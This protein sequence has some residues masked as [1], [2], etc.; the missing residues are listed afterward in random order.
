MKNIYEI[1]FSG[2]KKD[3]QRY[4]P[5]DDQRDTSRLPNRHYRVNEFNQYFQI[6]CSAINKAGGFDLLMW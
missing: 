4:N 6:S 3:F 1:F 2:L 5:A